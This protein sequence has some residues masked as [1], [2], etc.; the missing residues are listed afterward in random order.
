MSVPRRWPGSTVVCLA[1]GPSLTV[2]DVEWVRGRAR[3]IAVND[4]YRWAPWADALYATDVAW[5]LA[6]QGARTC[7]GEKWSIAHPTWQGRR[8]RFPEVTVLANTGVTGL[9]TDPSG[10]RHGKNSGYAA[11]NL[12]VH[13]GAAR[14]VLVGYDMGHPPGG[15][16]HFAGHSGQLVRRS[17]YADFR[18]TFQTIVAP[19][20]ALGIELVNC[21]RESALTCVPR[22]ALADVLTEVVA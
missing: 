19:V 16:S 9:E 22:R 7:T 1:T 15:R 8:E 10:I 14:I 20:R 12:A 13:Y 6:H 2:A 4:A 3:V 18:T 5:W 17:P 11:V 21:S